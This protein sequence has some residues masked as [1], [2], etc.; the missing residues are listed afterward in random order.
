[1]VMEDG[2]WQRIEIM[3]CCSCCLCTMLSSCLLGLESSP[4]SYRPLLVRRDTQE[5]TTWAWECG[6]ADGSVQ[7]CAGTGVRR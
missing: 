1:M 4:S 5:P 2:C 6:L 7:G 3:S